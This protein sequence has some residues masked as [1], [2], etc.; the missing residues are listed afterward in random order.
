MSLGPTCSIK[1]HEPYNT[2]YGRGTYASQLP[3]QL[4]TPPP[5]VEPETQR[6]PDS[7][8]EPTIPVQQ[9]TIPMI[10]AEARHQK[11]QGYKR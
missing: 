10:L 9:V 3:T 4:F 5:S 1:G 8:E 7:R 6:I 11:P 2:R